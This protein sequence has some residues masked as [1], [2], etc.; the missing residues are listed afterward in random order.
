MKKRSRSQADQAL[1]APQ[2]HG[3]ALPPDI[4]TA[5]LEAFRADLTEHII[6]VVRSLN[7]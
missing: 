2:Q 6:E 1:A 7:E 4:L 5:K 3:A